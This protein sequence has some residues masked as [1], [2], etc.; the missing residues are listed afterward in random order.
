MLYTIGF[1]SGGTV[2]ALRSR[3]E[4]Y[5][6]ATGGRAFFPTSAAELDDVFDEIVA[7]LANQY[8]LTYAPTNVAQDDQ[9]RSITVQVR[10][11]KY[12]VRARQGYRL[13]RPPQAGR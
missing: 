9:W 13:K 6:K 4:D 3:L 2:P 11:G 5:A 12:D 8:V 7:E 10:S 1:G